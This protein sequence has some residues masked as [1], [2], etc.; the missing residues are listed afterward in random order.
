MAIRALIVAV[1]KYPKASGLAA[2]LPGTND[3]ARAFCQ[4]LA[5]KKGIHPKGSQGFDPRAF[6]C[7]AG[8][9]V[10]FRTH[11]TT[12][13]EIVQAVEDLERAA[14]QD[15]E[16]GTAATDELYCFFSGH[17]LCYPRDEAVQE[18]LFIASDF[19]TMKQSGAA[20][21]KVAELIELLRPA[22]GPGDQYYFFDACR[23]EVKFGEIRPTG[24][25]K[26]FERVQSEFPGQAVLFS[27]AQGLAART[28]S[29]FAKHL[30]D[31]LNGKGRA[32]GWYREDLYVKFDFLREYLETATKKAVDGDPGSG[33]GL[34]LK[35]EP[36]PAEPC[37]IKVQDAE[38]SDRFAFTVKRR[39]KPIVAG[40][41][42]GAEHTVVIDEPGD[43]QV[44]V[45]HPAAPVVRV[46]PPAA[47]PVDLYDPAEVHFRKLTGPA[48]RG[49]ES[50]PIAPGPEGTLNV[51]G[52]P[53]ASIRVRSV[54][55]IAKEPEVFD[56]VSL[57]RLVPPGDFL[58]EVEEAGQVVARQTVSVRA[59]Q[60]V[61]ADPLAG[62]SS[63]LRDGLLQFFPRDGHAVEFSESLGGA[64]ADR[65]LGLWLS[66]IGASRVVGRDGGREFSKLGKV[67]LKAN[68]EAVPP[69]RAALFVLA[70]FEGRLGPYAIG[71]GKDPTWAEM[72][73]V[74]GVEG[75]HEFSVEVEPGSKLVTFQ[76][77]GAPPVTLSTHALAN[78][79]TLFALSNGGG[80]A[81][82]KL[83][84]FLLPIHALMG[85]LPAEVQ[86]RV[87]SIPPLQTTRFIVKVE[88]LF[89]GDRSI[90]K[91]FNP[92]EGA[93][94]AASRQQYDE[95]I[96]AKWLDPVASLIAANDLLRRGVLG[97]RPDLA[98]Y[99]HVLPVM[100]ANFRRFFGEI[101]DVEAVAKAIAADWKLPTAPPMLADSLTAFNLEE[102]KAFMPFSNDRRHFGTPWVAWVGAVKPFYPLNS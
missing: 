22:L 51:Q 84:Q 44:E 79:A 7:C 88:R 25:G 28:D 30:V 57:S 77:K 11:G 40:E 95:L 4:W 73:P 80:L 36:V 90:N 12:R 52:A 16:N 3:A 64:T 50:A 5:D 17:G 32:K 61:Q 20:C 67:P 91:V 78:R 33:D 13:P 31:G 24:M 102:Q 97:G 82:I 86:W 29:G 35:V 60:T 81:P 72:T 46:K 42:E 49:L 2:E 8:E 9:E 45:T 56:S 59:G 87:E 101:P 75:L 21:L 43:Y 55:S 18:D 94:D 98:R 26:V 63:P 6:F 27:V 89:A 41:F 68:F 99:K 37:V 19:T 70:G 15:L 66:L 83:Y 92:D 38:P 34:I 62:P 74:E 96:D 1:Q 53:N 23:I 100:V 54:Q 10:E 69:G 85:R 39:N 58:V 71:V 93:V 48:S 76:T 65:D 14:K 47:R